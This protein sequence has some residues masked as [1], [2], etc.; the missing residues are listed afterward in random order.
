MNSIYE[1]WGFTDNPFSTEPL[2]PNEIGAKLLVGRQDE[3]TRLANRIVSGPK[4]PT[5]EGGVGT[6]KTSLV[7]VCTYQLFSQFLRRETETLIIPC[8]TAFQLTEDSDTEGFATEVY[9]E[10]AQTLLA[11]GDFTQL[12]GIDLERR[13]DI[14]RWLN[15]SISK[16]VQGGLSVLG[17]GGSGGASSS[18][19]STAGFDKSGFRKQVASWLE[20]IFDRFS[21]GIVCII[22]NM[23]LLQESAAAKKSIEALR[24]ELLLK[25]G[26]RWVLCGANGIIQSVVAS[27]RLQGILYDPIIV[28]GIGDDVIP[29]VLASRTE[30]FE[31]FSGSG[32]LPITATAFDVLY[33]ALNR[34][35]RNLLGQCVDYCMWIT[36]SGLHPQDENDKDNGFFQWFEG[37]TKS[38]YDAVATQIRPRA[39]EVF[40]V[41]LSLGGRFFAK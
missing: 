24:D 29:R 2:Q 31:R 39:W 38:S 1:D 4:I 21:G 19:S 25:R 5:I 30:A 8:R 16:S 36:D 9:R 28:G 37:I 23:E 13:Q 7:N 27:P 40:D 10:V 14:D 18:L 32:Y 11:M 26:F 35:L 33:Q 22:D 34:N 17:F 41:A 20:E 3:L 15:S 12:L 6:G